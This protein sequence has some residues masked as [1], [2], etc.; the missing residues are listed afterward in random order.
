MSKVLVFSDLH[1]HAHKNSEDR[2][3]DCL[4][5]L[6]W[7]FQTALSRNIKTLLFC[8]DLFHDRQ[9]IDVLAYQKTFEIFEK[10]LANSVNPPLNVYLL[11]GNHDLW[12]LEKC[13]VSSVFP[14]R[15]IPGVTV[16]DRPS[17]LEIEGKEISFLPY[18]HNPIADLSTIQNKDKFKILCGHIAIDGAVMNKIYGIHS[19]TSIEHDGDMIKVD[20]NIFHDW[21][22]VFLG[23]YHCE[24]Q[25]SKN[26]EYVGS[27]LQLSFG[28]AFQHKHIIVYDLETHEKEYV[29]NKFSPQHF[30][31][32]KKDI[33]KYD[34]NGN[35]IEIVLEDDADSEITDIRSSILHNNHP[36][37]LRF[38]TEKK[39]DDD[40]IIKEATAVLNKQ[41]EM[42][43]TWIDVQEKSGNLKLEK[44]KLL[45]IG[46]IICDKAMTA[47]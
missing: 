13:D 15:N 34:L 29:R 35:F 37:S 43:E 31:I 6:D 16:I 40:K 4:N 27:P 22:Q 23:H 28:E 39:K 44:D 33:S 21:H 41:G 20:A 45:M 9:K 19:E 5:V 8:G 10:Y 14:L 42:L 47:A 7:V 11:L 32:P 30:I 18:T 24:Q 1:I 3:Q 25:L 26:A 12:Y 36:A 46:K 2:L 17:T 38:K